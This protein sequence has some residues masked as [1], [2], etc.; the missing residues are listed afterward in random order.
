MANA[1]DASGFLSPFAATASV[2]SRPGLDAVDGFRAGRHGVVRKLLSAEEIEAGRD[3][4][5]LIT[6]ITNGNSTL[7]FYAFRPGRRKC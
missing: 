7:G 3:I 2:A 5:P 4:N 6:D 1:P